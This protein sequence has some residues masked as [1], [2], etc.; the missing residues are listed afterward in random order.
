MDILELI[1]IEGQ[2]NQSKKHKCTAPNCNKAFG[3]K[4]GTMEGSLRPWAI[5]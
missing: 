1:N 4:L 5:D 2:Q 3:K